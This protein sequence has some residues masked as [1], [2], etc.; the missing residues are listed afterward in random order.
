[1]RKDALNDERLL[2]PARPGGLGQEDLRH[3]AHRQLAE[4][5]ILARERE[6]EG[7]RGGFTRIRHGGPLRLRAE[8]DP[9]VTYDEDLAGAERGD[10]AE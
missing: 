2:E 9:A 1:M 10:V 4:K 6:G 5:A 8:H 3:A 7:R